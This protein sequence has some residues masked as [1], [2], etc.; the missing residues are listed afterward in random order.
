M[1]LG[2]FQRSCMMEELVSLMD[3]GQN[4]AFNEDY[5]GLLERH[6]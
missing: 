4:L 2:S 1:L 6:C 5:L 3:I